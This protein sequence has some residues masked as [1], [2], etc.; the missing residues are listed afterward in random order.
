MILLIID[1]GG[2]YTYV[3]QSLAPYF[4]TVVYYQPMAEAY[5]RSPQ[6]QIG[7]GLP[8]VEWTDKRSRWIDKADV[9]FFPDVYGSDMQ[10]ELFEHGYPVVGSG[11]G[12]RMELDKAFFLDK[13]SEAR[14]AIPST[15]EVHGLDELWEHVKDLAP[16][17]V[18]LKNAE[19]YRGD[20]ETCEF[21]NKYE[22]ELTI[23]AKK[24]TLGAE[25]SKEIKILTQKRLDGL[26]IG[27]DTFMLNGQI[28]SRNSAL[29]YEIKDEGIIER[30]FDELPGS[31]AHV[32]ESLLPT[33]KKLGYRGPYSL[34]MRITKNGSVYPMDATCRC[35]NPPTGAMLQMYGKSYADA[36]VSLSKGK[37]P[38][39][40]SRYQYGAEIVLASLWHR[41][42]E[43]HVGVPKDLEKHL[44]LKNAVRRNG[45]YYCIP[46][47]PSGSDGIFGS[48]AC[49]GKTWK[50]A[51]Q[52]AMGIVKELSVK[53]LDYKENLFDECE[54][55]IREG[56]QVGI[57]F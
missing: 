48:V 13:L 6:S 41:D 50:E 30:V 54:K 53:Q 3:A 28:P 17:S 44:M 9:I 46:N 23:N 45:Q 38:D 5:L 37:L 18:Y 29:G 10:I 51:A 14:L 34:E 21:K 49:G 35:G 26:E 7:R 52:K 25:R 33:Y 11:K 2:L 8:G 27:I 16:G 20:W 36:L 12:S 39:L 4:Q 55:A 1:E 43:L 47:D 24:A 22:T 31:I 42:N 15:K 40:E 32:Q 19:K 56:E 57:H